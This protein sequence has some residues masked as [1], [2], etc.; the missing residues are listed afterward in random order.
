PGVV[1]L[2]GHE[3]LTGHRRRDQLGHR[4]VRRGET[5]VRNYQQAGLIVHADDDQF[6]RLGHVAI[7]NTRQVEFGKETMQD[8]FLSWGGHTSGPPADT[9]WLRIHHTVNEAGEH[10]YRSAFSTDG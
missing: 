10:L 5:E 9:T 2:L 3:H 7:W 6:L 8:G 4:L 1:E